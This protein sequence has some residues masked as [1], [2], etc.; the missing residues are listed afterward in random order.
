MATAYTQ[1]QIQGT[2]AGA[3]RIRSPLE[4]SGLDAGHG[5][6]RGRSIGSQI[7][8]RNA[9]VE[10]R[11][12]RFVPAEQASRRKLRHKRGVARADMLEHSFHFAEERVSASVDDRTV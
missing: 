10:A 7:I 4:C 9:K 6:Q 5:R 2:D 12:G 3:A 8:D 1:G 11:R